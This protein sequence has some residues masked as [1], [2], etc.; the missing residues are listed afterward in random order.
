TTRQPLRV[1]QIHDC[2]FGEAKVRGRLRQRQHFPGGTIHRCGGWLRGRV[3]LVFLCPRHR[4]SSFLRR[5]LWHTVSS[6]IVS[7]PATQPSSPPL[8]RPHVRPLLR[9]RPLHEQHQKHQRHPHR[10]TQKEHVE[11]GQRRRLLQ[12]EV[13]QHL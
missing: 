12:A 4:Y 9:H 6:S 5:R 2:R 8:P 11:V 3:R 13:G 10:R 1:N 7:R